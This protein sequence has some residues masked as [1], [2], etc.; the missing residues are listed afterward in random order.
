L[1]IYG[2][3][4]SKGGLLLIIIRLHILALIQHRWGNDFR[5]GILPS[6]HGSPVDPDNRNSGGHK[7]EGVVR[8]RVGPD[9]IVELKMESDWL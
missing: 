5:Y 8:F 7:R 2:G 4:S 6:E 1:S 9:R 3:L